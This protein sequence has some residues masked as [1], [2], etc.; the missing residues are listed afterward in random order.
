MDVPEHTQVDLHCTIVSTG[1]GKQG[2]AKPGL[3]YLISRGTCIQ[4]EEQSVNDEAGVQDQLD[5]PPHPDEEG[6]LVG[7]DLGVVEDAQPHTRRHA[8]I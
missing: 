6:S 7:H 5:V 2:Q 4:Q 8:T 1:V 3:S